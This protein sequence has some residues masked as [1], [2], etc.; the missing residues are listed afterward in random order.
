[1]NGKS[2]TNQPREMCKITEEKPTCCIGNNEKTGSSNLSQEKLHITLL[3]IQIES[4]K[5][6]P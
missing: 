4:C 5:F 1:M 3:H 6:K 2:E